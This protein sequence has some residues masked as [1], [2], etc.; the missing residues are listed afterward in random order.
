MTMDPLSVAM[1]EAVAVLTALRDP[2]DRE[3]NIVL[4]VELI[5]RAASDP[6]HLAA[7]LA[8][9]AGQVLDELDD[10]CGDGTADRWLEL[11]GLAVALMPDDP[12]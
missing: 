4:A 7:M 1:S 6:R 12:L 9:F 2:E 5:K 8:V 3:P 11:R 10:G